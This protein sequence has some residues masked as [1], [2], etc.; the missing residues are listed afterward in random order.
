MMRPMMYNDVID[1][2]HKGDSKRLY[3]PKESCD[4]LV[5]Y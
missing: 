3:I 4:M 1:F 5:Q 2:L